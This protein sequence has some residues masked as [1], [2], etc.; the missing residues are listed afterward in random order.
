MGN[1]DERKTRPR[2][3]RDGDAVLPAAFGRAI[4]DPARR[5]RP[6]SPLCHG[7]ED[8]CP[9][10][11]LLGC[12]SVSFR[13]PGRV[14]SVPRLGTEGQRG[15]EGPRRRV[16]KARASAPTAGRSFWT[17]S[18]LCLGF[19]LIGCRLLTPP[20][21][22][23]K[24]LWPTCAWPGP[25]CSSGAFGAPGRGGGPVH[26]PALAFSGGHLGI[27]VAFQVSVTC[28]SHCGY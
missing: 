27:P 23:S 17:A 28:R 21:P 15:S 12:R 8:S 16:P 24:S 14:A 26:S 5:E 13:R 7:P 20:H 19:G 9:A 6:S 1:S 3:K 25:G 18:C 22:E 2:Q 4:L 11:A 10:A